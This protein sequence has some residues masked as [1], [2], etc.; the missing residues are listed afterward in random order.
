MTRVTWRVERKPEGDDAEQF[1]LWADVGPDKRGGETHHWSGEISIARSGK[2]CARQM[3]FRLPDGAHSIIENNNAAW[4]T[5]GV[6]ATLE[7]TV[8]LCQ[9]ESRKI[10]DL[11]TEGEGRASNEKQRREEAR[12]TLRSLEELGTQIA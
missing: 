2:V 1:I 9:A 6:R 5:E 11:G 10:K 12:T 7:W 8:K 3:R 4:G